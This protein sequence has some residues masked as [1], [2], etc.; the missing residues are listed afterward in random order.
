MAGTASTEVKRA[1]ME[2]RVVLDLR[3]S[4]EEGMIRCNERTVVETA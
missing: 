1:V 4:D 2:M 3:K